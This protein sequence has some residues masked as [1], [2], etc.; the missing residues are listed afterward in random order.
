[1]RSRGRGSCILK[2]VI[3][4]L[5][6]T[7]N[8]WRNKRRR[9]RRGW[10]LQNTGDKTANRAV[11][12][13][14]VVR[15]QRAGPRPNAWLY[16]QQ[17]RVQ[18]QFRVREGSGHA[19]RLRLSDSARTFRSLHATIT[20]R[21]GRSSS[22]VQLR[23][24]LPRPLHRTRGSPGA[25][26]CP[27][28]GNRR[29]LRQSPDRASPDE[30][31]AGLQ[32][33][34]PLRHRN[35]PW[36]RPRL[37]ARRWVGWSCCFFG[38]FAAR[39]CFFLDPQ[40]YILPLCMPLLLPGL[41]S[42]VDDNACVEHRCRP[43]SKSLRA[44]IGQSPDHVTPLGRWLVHG[45]ITWSQ[46]ACCVTWLVWSAVRFQFW[47]RRWENGVE[48]NLH[49]RGRLVDRKPVCMHV[50]IQLM[51][52]RGNMD[53]VSASSQPPASQFL[54]FLDVSSVVFAHS[55]YSDVVLK[56]DYFF[57]AHCEYQ[58]LFMSFQHLFNCRLLY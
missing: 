26:L 6:T 10:L 3:L 7:K 46:A 39:P 18:R 40:K 49:T 50:S 53:A 47:V 38:F 45:V 32:F 24:S 16:R 15:F 12:G 41:P 52:V 8:N 35:G 55:W 42:A 4:I 9:R 5:R 31:G 23:E 14:S 54:Y 44:L 2:H 28:S 1:M 34:G 17:H 21:R 36:G 13:K 58:I 51:Q 25:C 33:W 37:R 22:L 48:W 20:R 19:E 27:R 56:K 11:Y 57:Y 29:P 43:A 30:R